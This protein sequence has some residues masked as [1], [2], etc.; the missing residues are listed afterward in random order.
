M[1]RKKSIYRYAAL[2]LSACLLR[3]YAHSQELYPLTE[4]ASTMPKSVW[5]I[6]LFTENYRDKPYI[7]TMQG[8]RIMYGITKN[9]T[10]YTTAIFSNHHG[11]KFPL[12]FPYHNTPERGV[13]YPYKYNGQ[14]FYTKY[15]IFSHDRKNEH[16]RIALY[17]EGT[18]VN[19]THHESEPNLLMGDNS[20][21]GGGGI[22]TY[23]KNK[24][25]V[26]ATVGYIHSF[27]N[28]NLTPDP[29]ESLPDIPI[30]VAYGNATTFSLAAGYLL[31]PKAYESYDQTN[32]N[33]YI[34][35]T[36]KRFGAGT[37]DM[38]KGTD[39]EYRLLDSRYPD[40]FRKGYVVDISPSIQAIIK[41]NLRIDASITL[42]FLG[43]TYAKQYPLFTLGMQYYIY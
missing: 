29:I 37:V 13:K 40:A 23:L 18:Y 10:A 26:S 34:E 39:M 19:T 27:G 8:V 43:T 15:R 25:A 22:V 1:C 9:W 20:G 3:Q 32:I 35:L 4:P 5:G 42:P 6:R 16:L 33:L 28:S 31:L 7:R 21:V 30:R 12:E 24:L 14:H 41:S 11:K 38:F 36:G 17:G 2:M